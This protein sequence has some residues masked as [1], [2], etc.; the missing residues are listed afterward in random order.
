MEFVTYEIA[1]KLKEKRFREGCLCSYRNYSKTLQYNRVESKIVRDVY[2][3]EFYKCYNSFEESNID[4]PTISQ[5]LDWLRKEKKIYV[6]ISYMPKILNET[7]ILNDFYYPTFQK[8]GLFEPMFFIGNGANYD[9]WK[10]AAL[11]GIEYVLD[12][13]I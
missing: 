12:N 7:G 13:L 6:G 8:I 4:A 5:V 3:L 9:T 2:Y 1:K 10:E 11:A